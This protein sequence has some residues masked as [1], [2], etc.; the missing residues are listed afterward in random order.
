MVCAKYMS[1]SALVAAAAL[2]AGVDATALAS[3]VAYAPWHH[4]SVDSSVI[5]S[6]FA[7]VGTYFQRIRTFQTLF[8]SVNAIEAAASAGLKIAAGVQLTDSSLIQTEIDAVC[9]AVESYADSVEAV[10]VGNEDLINADAS[11]GSFTSDE[12]IGY[13]NQVKAC[14][15]D[16]GIPV[17]TVQRINEWLET[18]NAASLKASCDVIG[19]NIYPF[20]TNGDDSAVTKL[21][22]QYE[23]MTTAGYDASTLH[24]TETGWPYA[25]SEYEG[26][27]PS[28]DGMQQY[29]D[30]F[31]TWSSSDAHYFFMMFDTTTSYSGEDY[32]THFGLFGS[33]CTTQHVTIPSGDG[34]TVSTNTTSTASSTADDYSDDSA[35]TYDDETDAS[36]TTD[37]TATEAPATT[38]AAT[39]APTTSDASTSTDAAATEAPAATPAATETTETTTTDAPAATTT[40]ATAT[41]S[42]AVTPAATGSSKNCAM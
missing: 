17:G 2:A 19:V 26:N 31:A 4:T 23:Q 39:P 22:T 11:F 25:G 8:S 14:V 9:S 6:D 32:E 38:E 27:T 10:Y 36:T 40:D 1:V 13:I 18:D 41:D 35:S 20:F 29:I 21:E 34:T 7:I 30:D 42:P 28:Y 3:G 15:S 37:A 24:V 16:Y 5:A 33:D 12:L